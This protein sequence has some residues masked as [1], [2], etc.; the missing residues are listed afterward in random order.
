MTSRTA[1][2]QSLHASS[3]ALKVIVNNGLAKFQ[4][5]KLACN[6]N[7]VHG[8]F[9][10][11]LCEVGFLLLTYPQDAAQ[12]LF[13]SSVVLADIKCCWINKCLQT[14]VPPRIT[15][16][17][18]ANSGE[19]SECNLH[20]DDPASESKVETNS[21]SLQGR[22][23]DGQFALFLKLGDSFCPLFQTH[24]S[25]EQSLGK[26]RLWNTRTIPWNTRNWRPSPIMPDQLQ[27]QLIAT[28]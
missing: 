3:F 2:R 22:D 25:L 13:L 9:D 26:L 23:H 18:L 1:P 10:N 20:R 16:D 14:V 8:I 19:W 28:V 15:F 6:N 27:L 11:Y 5:G 12:S 7:R 24:A 21:S 4:G 17:V